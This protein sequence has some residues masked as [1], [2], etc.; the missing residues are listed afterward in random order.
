MPVTYPITMPTGGVR[1]VMFQQRSV[2]AVQ[3]SPF[4]F[5]EKTYAWAGQ[6]WEMT[7]ELVPMKRATS[8]PWL[9]ALMSLNGRE[10]TFYFGDTAYASPRGVGTG[11]PLIKGASQTG[12]DLI[13]DGWTVS[14]TGILKAGDWI[15]LGSGST[16]RLHMV[17][18]D[19]DSDA[20]GD[21]TITLWPRVRSAFADD[22]A[23]TTASPKGVFRLTDPASWNVDADKLARGLT[24]T[25]M[26]AL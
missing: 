2:V 5:I 22:T 20:S 18:A 4:T 14:T 25:A 15:Q 24:F 11:T 21:S 10:G 12:Y 26:E 1:R 16:Q 19:A 23:I 13:T 6:A 9:A 8:A 17:M 7:V 3:P